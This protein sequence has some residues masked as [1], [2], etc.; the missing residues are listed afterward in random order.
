MTKKRITQEMFDTNTYWQLN[1][2]KVGDEIESE[3]LK[4][5]APPEG[6]QSETNDNEGLPD[7]TG[8][9]APPPDKPRDD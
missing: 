5:E 1:G 4:L 6:L 7:D 8:G 3:E 9:S 2:F